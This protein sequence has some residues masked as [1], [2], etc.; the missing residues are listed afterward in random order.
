MNPASYR[1]IP[2]GFRVTLKRK[3]TRKKT[4]TVLFV[5][6]CIAHV[7]ST[8]GWLCPE[9]NVC[10]SYRCGSKTAGPSGGSGSGTS[11]W[12]C[13]KT[14]TCRS[15]AGSCSPTMICTQ[16]TPTTTGPTRVSPRHRCPPR[17]SLSSTPWAPSRRS[18]CSQRLTPSP[19]WPWPPGWA[20]PQCRACPPR[21][22]TTSVTWTES[23]RPVSIRLCH[24]RRVHTGLPALR[25]VFTGTLATP[26]WPPSDSNPN[27]TQLSDTAASRVPAPVWMPVSTTADGPN[28]G[29]WI[30]E[31]Y[32][33]R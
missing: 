3:K 24:R 28:A 14:A 31:F 8:S 11:R 16:L 7:S 6:W 29:P 9:L 17:T 18:L 1:R 5:P 19:P 26:A 4:F 13:A 27:S 30:S 15:S 22:S 2:R 33:Y 23:A 12:T 20:T 21:V 25:T 10:V 32:N